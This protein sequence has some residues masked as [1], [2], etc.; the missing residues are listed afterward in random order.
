[1]EYHILPMQDVA[2]AMTV[3]VLPSENSGYRS[4]KWEKSKKRSGTSQHCY[5]QDEDGLFDINA[6][7]AT[8]WTCDDFPHHK[9]DLLAKMIEHS[10]YTRFA[11]YASF[12]HADYKNTRGTRQLFHYGKVWN[13]GKEKDEWKWIFDKNV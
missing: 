6:K 4:Y 7:G 8:D 2:D 5:G 1:M 3:C 11:V 12:I 10:E 13:E 9:D